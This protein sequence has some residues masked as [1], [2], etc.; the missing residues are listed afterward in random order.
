MD[1][2]DPT[3]L[4]VV[5]AGAQSFLTADTMFFSEGVDNE[6]FAFTPRQLHYRH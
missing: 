3:W 4:H 1:L 2:K 6:H 5:E